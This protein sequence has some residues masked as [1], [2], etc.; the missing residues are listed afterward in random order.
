[1]TKATNMALGADGQQADPVSALQM[2]N[3]SALDG[4]TK[5]ELRAAL[6][7]GTIDQDDPAFVV[8]LKN[9]IAGGGQ[10]V[11]EVELARGVAAAKLSVATKDKLVKLQ[12]SVAGP[13]GEIIKSAF[14]ALD[15]AFKKSMTADGTPAQALAHFAAHSELQFAVEEG[16]RKGNILDLLNP[17][18]Q[19]YVLP[20]IMQRHQLSTSEQ[21]RAMQ[22]KFAGSGQSQAPQRKADESITEYQRRISGGTQ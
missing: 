17:Q 10:P 20:G 2:I 9:R 21:I 16:I 22:D 4:K 8:G 3:E 19:N 5:L 15:E 11:T 6:Q 1:M 18:S 13:Q 12:E 14:R 7:K